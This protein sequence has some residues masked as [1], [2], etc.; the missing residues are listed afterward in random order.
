VVYALNTS[1]SAWLGPFE[2][3]QAACARA[4]DVDNGWKP[5]DTIIIDATGRTF[6]PMHVEWRV[7]QDPNNLPPATRSNGVGVTYPGT[8]ENSV[9]SLLNTIPIGRPVK[10]ILHTDNVDRYI[11]LT[12]DEE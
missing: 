9:E 10:S 12:R 5:S 4:L 8:T 1:K 2:S 3:I 6:L 7:M 11:G